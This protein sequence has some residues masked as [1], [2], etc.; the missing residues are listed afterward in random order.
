MNKKELLEFLEAADVE[1]FEVLV[2][3]EHSPFDISPTTSPYWEKVT[4]PEKVTL[5]FSVTVRMGQIEILQSAD[6]RSK[7]RLT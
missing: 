2:E 6:G 4:Y 3:Y 5:K 1:S 7:F